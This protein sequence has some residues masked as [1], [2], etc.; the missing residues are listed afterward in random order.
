M[1]YIVFCDLLASER[2]SVLL[3][4]ERCDLWICQQ[5]TLMRIGGAEND[6]MGDKLS[7]T[8]CYRAHLRW[9]PHVGVLEL[10]IHDEVPFSPGVALTELFASQFTTEKPFAESN[11]R[12][13]ITLGY[14]IIMAAVER[15]YAKELKWP[16]GRFA[17]GIKYLPAHRVSAATHLLSLLNLENDDGLSHA[18]LHD[19]LEANCANMLLQDGDF[20]QIA[21]F[22]A[23]D[24]TGLY[25]TL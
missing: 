1:L 10:H 22:V 18:S 8:G 17:P 16:L 15:S 5:M 19:I 24:Q 7:T 9:N 13:Y 6:A 3:G 20:D 2:V 14:L 4:P 12:R 23:T 21:R 25:G 11:H